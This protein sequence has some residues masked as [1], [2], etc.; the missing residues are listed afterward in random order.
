[1]FKTSKNKLGVT[2]TDL[3][4]WDGNRNLEDTKAIIRQHIYNGLP[5]PCLTLK[6]ESPVMDNYFLL[7][8]TLNGYEA[9]QDAFMV[10]AVTYGTW[11]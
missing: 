7:L 8:Y 10:K 9:F 3:S 6:H 1:M 11:R 5:I 2:D 4:P